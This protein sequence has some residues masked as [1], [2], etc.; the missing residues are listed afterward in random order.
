MSRRPVGISAEHNLSSLCYRLASVCYVDVRPWARLA[1]RHGL[2]ERAAKLIL[3]RPHESRG[4]FLGQVDSIVAELERILTG[5][6]YERPP[7]QPPPKT[8]L[9]LPLAL[10]P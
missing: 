3:D 10:Q 6:A 8:S 7:L 9:M 1:N 4:A 5:V 2:A